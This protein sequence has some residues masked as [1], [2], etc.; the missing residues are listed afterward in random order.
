[1]FYYYLKILSTIPRSKAQRGFTLIELLVTIVIIAILAGVA[2]PSMLNQANKARQSAAK[3]HIGAVNRA[4]QAYRLEE[5]T[6]ANDMGLL[7]I[8]ISLTTDKYTYSFGTVNSTVAEF[9]ATPTDPLLSAIT[10]CTN[11][12]IVSG[13]L[14]TTSVTLEEQSLPGSGNIAI[15]PSC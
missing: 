5:Q 12:N 2:L 14:A 3:S 9:R 8:G 4:Q 13:S 1:M 10:G 15:P 6:F 7:G 11:A